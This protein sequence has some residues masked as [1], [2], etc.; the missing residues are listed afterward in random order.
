MHEAPALARPR[1]RGAGP[2]RAA[3]SGRPAG[4]RRVC[5]SGAPPRCR[6][7]R[8]PGTCDPSHGVP[9]AAAAAVN[10]APWPT[11]HGPGLSAAAHP[12][13]RPAPAELRS[14]GEPARLAPLD[15]PARPGLV[16]DRAGRGGTVGGS[17]AGRER[18]AR[19]AGAAV[20]ERRDLPGRGPAAP[21]PRHAARAFLPR[22]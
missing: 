16:G 7:R 11:V 5:A 20:T 19:V 18:A 12:P 6:H 8:P 2:G 10:A 21:R 9:L 17:W 4:L 3:G 1:V 15:C 13:S 22:R 14:R